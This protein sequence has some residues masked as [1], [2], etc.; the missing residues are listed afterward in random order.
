MKELERNEFAPIYVARGDSI[1]A[2]VRN[3]VTGEVLSETRH[4][5]EESTIVD[6]TVIFSADTMFGL[7]NVIGAVFGKQ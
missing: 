5:F 2:T 7:K 1:V 6:T 3:T 4:E